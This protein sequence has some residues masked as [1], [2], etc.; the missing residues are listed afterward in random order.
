MRSSIK[1]KKP[2]VLHLRKSK[3]T[4]TIIMLCF[5][6]TTAFADPM[7]GEQVLPPASAAY[8]TDTDIINK[9]RLG[10]PDQPVWCYSNDANAILVTAPQIAK[11]R[12]ELDKEQALEKLKIRMQLDIDRLSVELTSVKEEY[13]EVLAVKNQEIERLTT[14]ALKR[15]ND[16]SVWWL[17]G[18]V[19]AGVL[20]TLA[21][22]YA[23]R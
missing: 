5:T 16:Y 17:T 3:V 14:A 13:A 21:V 12:C 19:V 15:P 9:L 11:E 2:S 6:V 20:S 1:L 10:P 23:V 8:V 22:V 7:V 18:G 4:A